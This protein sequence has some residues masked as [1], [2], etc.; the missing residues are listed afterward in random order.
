MIND[1]IISGIIAGVVIFILYIGFVL[2]RN[3]PKPQSNTKTLDDLLEE[4][5]ISLEKEEYEKVIIID[6][7]INRIKNGD[8]LN[9]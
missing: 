1:L 3:Y 4:R 7:K 9:P 6:K 5:R 8:T 2:G